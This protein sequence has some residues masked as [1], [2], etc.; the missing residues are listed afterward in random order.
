MKKRIS[1]LLGCILSV[2]LASCQKQSPESDGGKGGELVAVDV[3]VGGTSGTGSAESSGSTGSAGAAEPSKSAIYSDSSFDGNVSLMGEITLWAYSNESK[4]PDVCVS[5]TK[6]AAPKLWLRSGVTYSV[7]AV[8]NVELPAH[9]ERQ[10]MRKSEV[11]SLYESGHLEPLGNLPMMAMCHT[12]AAEGAGIALAFCHS[13][14][15]VNLKIDASGLNKAYKVSSAKMYAFIGT[16]YTECDYANPFELNSKIG[17]DI[18]L[19][20]PTTA[21]KLPYIEVTGDLSTSFKGTVTYRIK[22]GENSGSVAPKEYYYTLKPTLEHLVNKEGNEWEVEDNIYIADFTKFSVVADL[23]HSNYQNKYAS[24]YPSAWQDLSSPSGTSFSLALVETAQNIIVPKKWYKLAQTDG[25]VLLPGP[26][27]NISTGFVSRRLCTNTFEFSSTR[28]T[29]T[30]TYPIATIW[31]PKI[32]ALK[33]MP[34]CPDPS[35]SNIKF[36]TELTTMTYTG[37]MKGPS[38]SVVTPQAFTCV[39]SRYYNADSLLDGCRAPSSITIKGRSENP[40]IPV[41]ANNLTIIREIENQTQNDKWGAAYNIAIK[42]K[43][44]K[45]TLPSNLPEYQKYVYPNIPESEY[46]NTTIYI[47]GRKL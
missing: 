40:S 31:Q 21:T 22:V 5:F 7:V 1:I 42:N 8:C 16:R 12:T 27:D 18:E 35:L 26:S 37:I 45:Y 9:E 44:I 41:V 20:C 43:T 10:L 15:K 19:Y 28:A 13:W 39:V 36:S 14:A 23:N 24:H 11:L 32:L 30:L 17:S 38:G 29:N 25:E 46:T 4:A 47:N 33:A 2:C 6:D 3:F 34:S